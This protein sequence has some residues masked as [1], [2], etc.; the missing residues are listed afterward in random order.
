M[1]N[2]KA[3]SVGTSDTSRN[4]QPS[5]VLYLCLNYYASHVVSYLGGTNQPLYLRNSQYMCANAKTDDLAASD[6]RDSSGSHLYTS[7]GNPVLGQ[8]AGG[9]SDTE[10]FDTTSLF[11]NEGASG[12]TKED[13]LSKL[14]NVFRLLDLY[15][16]IGSGGLVEK[17]IVD[18]QSLHRLL[19]T[20][21]P[22]SY[23]LPWK[24]NF[25]LLDQLAIK[26][27]GLYGC[28][29][30][31]IK[32][33]RGVNCL[34]EETQALLAADSTSASLRSGLYIVIPLDVGCQ[35]DSTRNAY[36]MY[37][38]EDTTWEDK[39][40][41]SVRRNRVTFMRYLFKL[42]DQTIA[43]VS[44]QQADAIVWEA[45]A[46]NEDAP[47]E[48]VESSDESR[49]NFFEVAMFD[50][51]EEDVVASSGFVLQS[52][53]RDVPR[54]NNALSVTLA[55]GEEKVGLMVISH[56]PARYS[57]KGFDKDIATVALRSMIQSKSSPV[58]LGTNISPEHFALLGDL[59]L[60]AVY[61]KQF[62]EYDER[63]KT[64]KIIRDHE[65]EAE[66]K[67]IETELK[68]DKPRLKAFIIR[69]IQTLYYEIYPSA[70]PGI[71][72]KADSAEDASLCQRYPELRNLSGDVKSK[73]NLDVIEDHTFKDLKQAWCMTR[74]F[75]SQEPTPSNK[76]QT[77]FVHR[78]L[79]NLDEGHSVDEGG[80]KGKGLWQKLSDGVANLNPLQ[81]LRPHGETHD[82]SDPEFVAA[83]GSLSERYPVVS[84]LT[85]RVI[86]SLQAYHT[87]LEKRLEKEFTAR[88]AERERNRR[89]NLCSQ[90][91]VEAARSQSRAT[92][93]VLYEQLKEAMSLL[94]S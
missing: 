47:M 20:M 83:L 35:A 81:L 51:S 58:I 32:F 53:L 55:P 84:E 34:N 63:L 1:K 8:A 7:G 19:N 27:I 13:V 44:A 66:T 4:A 62:F 46:H 60:R 37:W 82:S 42:T 80:S 3:K 21:S 64:E 74:D 49:M 18:Q 78:V 61:P 72:Q 68:E 9:D 16:E 52:E 11:G 86:S 29:S 14:P 26:P 76:N 89:F 30:E 70:Y 75:I 12:P 15:Q 10:M 91:R 65:Y 54:L 79:F 56:E 23:E 39:A 22:G 57:Q 73:H 69:T 2:R 6:T 17:M 41:S 94:T 45:G 77:D 40:M 67:I 50:E 59:G 93:I 43:L 33:L 87:A 92:L 71:L 38:P 88:I 90:L 85:A 24:I 36:V 25:K 31:I 28:K 5:W 48:V